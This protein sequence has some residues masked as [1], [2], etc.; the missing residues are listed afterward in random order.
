MKTLGDLLEHQLKNIFSAEDQYLQVLPLMIHNIGNQELKMAFENNHIKTISH[1]IRIKEICDELKIN[2]EG[3]R[4]FVLDSLIM[5]AK[6]FMEGK[7]EECV[8]D[9]GI[10]ARA[11]RIAHYKIASYATAMQYAKEM[12]YDDIAAILFQ[13]HKEENIAYKKL[14][15]IAENRM[16]NKVVL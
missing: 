14:T 9:T 11:Q 5:E 8:M 4:C 15:R 7:M 1:Q 12:A 10:F 2:C 16:S 3:D 6:H 13:I